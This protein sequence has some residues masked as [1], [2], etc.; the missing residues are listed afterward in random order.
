MRTRCLI[1]RILVG[2][3]TATVFTDAICGVYAQSL[4][5]VNLEEAQI[6]TS[7]DSKPKLIHLEFGITTGFVLSRADLF[8]RPQSAA[9]F[10][11]VRLARDPALRYVA[12]VPYSD[13]LEYFFRLAPE[14]GDDIPLGSDEKPYTL[15]ARDLKMVVSHSNGRGAK[16]AITVAA[17]VGAILAIFIIAKMKNK[18]G[19]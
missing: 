4:P 1:A 13:K 15:E 7:I 3:L 16:T 12:S 9:R 18:N 2:L 14:R 19:P 8:Y 10:R 11:R 6:I 17:V 5:S